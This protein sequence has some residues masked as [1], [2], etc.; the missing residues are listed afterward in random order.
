MRTTAPHG[1]VLSMVTTPPATPDLLREINPLYQTMQ[2]YLYA[3]SHSLT[4]ITSNIDL[5]L[6]YLQLPID[7]ISS[8]II[9]Q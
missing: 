4:P 3:C 8:F 2:V 6:I 5:K 9:V 1:P 7:M